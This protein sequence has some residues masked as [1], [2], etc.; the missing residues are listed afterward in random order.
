MLSASAHNVVTVD[1]LAFAPRAVTQVLT[2]KHNRSRDYTVLRHRAYAGV[3]TVRRVLF[4]RTGEYLVVYDRLEADRQ[5]TFR[6]LWQL[7]VGSR[8]T[9]KGR[10]VATRRDRGNV[11]VVQAG[12][13]K[14]AL[15]LVSGATRPYQ[16]WQ[17]VPTE[18]AVPAPT[19]E[20][21]QK[22]RRA[23]YL[24]VIVPSRHGANVRVAN[25][26]TYAE[27]FRATIVVDGKRETVLATPN[28]AKVTPVN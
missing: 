2:A 18:R 15:R 6:Q 14:S 11:T 24:T 5:R 3:T 16:G 26:R 7:P 27:G 19:V 10:V 22:G 23:T 1:G 4:S 20:A 28:N 25:V 8:P 13:V 9:V 17:T 12:R 21:I